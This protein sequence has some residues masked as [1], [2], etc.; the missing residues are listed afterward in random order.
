MGSKGLCYGGLTLFVSMIGVLFCTNPSVDTYQAFVTA[1]AKD[2]LVDD[3]CPRPLPF[4]GNS[5]RD[6]CTDFLRSERSTPVIQGMIARSSDRHNFGVFSLY[7]TELDMETLMPALPRG[8]LPSYRIDAI[9]LGN[10]FMVYS[11]QS[12]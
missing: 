11:A 4:I 12:L 6:E 5:L 7:S 10:Q 8:L 1:E 2:Y 3:A 9:G